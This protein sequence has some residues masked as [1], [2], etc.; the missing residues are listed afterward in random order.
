[1][2]LPITGWLWVLKSQDRD[3]LDYTKASFC[4]LQND[5]KTTCRYLETYVSCNC[6]FQKR[7]ILEGEVPGTIFF[8][9]FP[10]SPKHMPTKLSN[11]QDGNQLK[12]KG[13]TAR[14][15]VLGVF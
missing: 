3:T 15:A 10:K 4:H 13:C 11:D 9:T 6:H 5:P 7:A 1:M 8:Q 12:T 2:N 14:S